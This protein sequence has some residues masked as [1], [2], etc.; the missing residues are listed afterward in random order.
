MGNLIPLLYQLCVIMYSI[1]L[2][3]CHRI[4]VWHWQQRVNPTLLT[5]I[6]ICRNVRIC[7][8]FLIGVKWHR[9]I[10]HQKKEVLLLEYGSS[11]SDLSVLCLPCKVLRCSTLLKQQRLLMF[12]ESSC[13]WVSGREAVCPRLWKMSS[14]RVTNYA[15]WVLTCWPSTRSACIKGILLQK[16]LSVCWDQ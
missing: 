1:V 15:V 7:Y 9:S 5:C 6:I 11:A 10:L 13:W 12:E 8:C 16:L 2:W 3:H 14:F 4:S